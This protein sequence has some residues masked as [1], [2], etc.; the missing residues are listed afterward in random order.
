MIIKHQFISFTVYQ[1]GDKFIFVWPGDYVIQ[2]D[3]NLVIRCGDDNSIVVISPELG[4]IAGNYELLDSFPIHQL[5]SYVQNF[6][7]DAYSKSAF[8]YLADLVD[9]FT[10]YGLSLTQ[11]KVQYKDFTF[12]IDFTK[13]YQDLYK[14]YKYGPYVIQVK[15]RESFISDIR[16]AVS[17]LT[18]TEK[19][20]NTTYKDFDIAPPEFRKAQKRYFIALQDNPNEPYEGEIYDKY[21]LSFL[22][23]VVH[24][25][26]WDAEKVAVLLQYCSGL[27]FVV[28]SID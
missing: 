27:K 8:T 28:T 10:R 11:D 12:D 7:Q 22:K 13:Y 1:V 2:T 15:L 14:F 17:G 16:A 6:V 5:L 4:L 21:N 20:L 25:S 19:V 18:A 9:D 24:I 23:E 26:K 3:P